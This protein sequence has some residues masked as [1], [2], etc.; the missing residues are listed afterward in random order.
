MNTIHMPGFT[1]EASI[2]KR[3]RGYQ[4]IANA[5]PLREFLI[6]V[7]P[8]QICDSNCLSQCIS[9]CISGCA[10]D[11]NCVRTCRPSCRRQCCPCPTTCGPCSQTCTDC[12]GNV[13]TRSC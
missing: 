13:T 2:S 10:G 9:D 1:A 3:S 6:G 11:L 12:L 8:Q 7:I 5:E 4:I